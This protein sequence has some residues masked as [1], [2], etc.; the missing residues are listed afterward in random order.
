MAN[1]GAVYLPRDAHRN[2]HRRPPD[3]TSHQ[4]AC[5][6]SWGNQRNFRRNILQ[7]RY[8]VISHNKG[9]TLYITTKV[10]RGTKKRVK[11]KYRVVG[12]IYFT[13]NTGNK[14]RCCNSCFSQTCFIPSNNT[15]AICFVHLIY[16]I[17]D[18]LDWGLLILSVNLHLTQLLFKIIIR[19]KFLCVSVVATLN[20]KCP[21]LRFL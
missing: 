21:A 20:C 13:F 3:L 19:E 11:R 2:E 6:H 14:S 10:Q 8:D 12:Q 4:R 15:S 16:L 7:Q 1:V 9:M 18:K 5:E 17:N